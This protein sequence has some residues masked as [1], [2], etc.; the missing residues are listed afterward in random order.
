MQGTDKFSKTT[1]AK[2]RDILYRLRDGD[3]PREVQKVLRKRL[4]RLCFYMTDFTRT[5]SEMTIDYFDLL[6]RTKRITVY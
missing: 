4:R 3:V 1:A 5:P 6:K 2:I